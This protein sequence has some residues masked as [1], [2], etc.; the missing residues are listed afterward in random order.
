[1]QDSNVAH[2]LIVLPDGTI[3]VDTD[4]AT[5]ALIAEE[6]KNTK[7]INIL[8][9]GGFN[10]NVFKQHA[11]QKSITRNEPITKPNTRA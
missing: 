11:Y 4:P 7:A 2:E 8:N 3:D 5:I 10:G 9:D 6:K 1:M